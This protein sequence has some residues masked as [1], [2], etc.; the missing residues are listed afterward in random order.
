MTCVKLPVVMR[1]RKKDISNMP[2]I[3]ITF[4]VILYCTFLIR[5]GCNSNYCNSFIIKFQNCII[6]KTLKNIL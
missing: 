1:T 5:I 4:I 6:I 2:I 3:F